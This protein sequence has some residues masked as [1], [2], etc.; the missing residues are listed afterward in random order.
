MIV[1]NNQKIKIKKKNQNKING[2]CP[3]IIVV[4]STTLMQCDRY[5]KI[6]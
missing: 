3:K 4:I 6:E 5:V 1:L 2:I